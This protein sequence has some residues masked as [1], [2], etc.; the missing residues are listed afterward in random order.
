MA[1]WIEST[2]NQFGYPGVALLMFLE[3]LV[4]PILSEVVMP[5]AGFAA[6]QG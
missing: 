6:A 2:M 1:Q 5:L 3:T 4:L